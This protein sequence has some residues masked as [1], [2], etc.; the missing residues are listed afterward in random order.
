MIL[1]V[2]DWTLIDAAMDNVV[3][4]AEQNGDG[5]TAEQGR[6]V[7]RTGW[8]AAA[9]HPKADMGWEGWPPLEDDLSIELP[10]TTWRFVAD[11]LRRW[12]EVDALVNPRGDG[13]PEPRGRNWPECWKK[14]SADAG[15]SAADRRRF[16]E[17]PLTGGSGV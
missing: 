12:D 16:W 6:I 15:S 9:H 10:A 7:R 11:Q 5:S 17:H 14:G 2:Q 8:V 4:I 3:A 13:D 1:S